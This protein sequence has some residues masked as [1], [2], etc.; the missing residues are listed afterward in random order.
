MH[1]CVTIAF[2]VV[3]VGGGVA[4]TGSSDDETPAATTNGTTAASPEATGLAS[5]SNSTANDDSA[6]TT[7]TATATATTTAASTSASSTRGT[8]ST[9]GSSAGGTNTTGESTGPM[10]DGTRVF[11][12]S[13]KYDGDLGGLVGGDMRCQAQA[14]AAALGGSWLAW[15]GDGT[16]APATRFAQSEFDYH[17]V[18]GDV[19]ADDWTDL[20]DGTLAAPIDRDETGTPLPADDD[21]VVWTAVFHTG[22]NPTPVNCS[23]WTSAGRTL[24]PTGLASATDTGWTVTAPRNCSESHRLY[25][26]EQ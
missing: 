3:L 23:G 10:L 11:V 5:M 8:E 15:L 24:V 14:D 4:C 26:F 17:L 25:C 6:D 1:C 12:T 7:A 22:G 19:I 21:M 20:I 16:D 2:V 9:S 13:T 18:G